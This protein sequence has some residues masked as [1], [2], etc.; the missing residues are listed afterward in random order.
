[1]ASVTWLCLAL[2]WSTQVAERPTQPDFSGDWVLVEPADHG[3]DVAVALTVRQPVIS[4]TARGTPMAPFYSHLNVDR[5]LATGDR[6]DSYMIGVRGGSV[7]ATAAG[8]TAESRQVVEW[9]GDTLV[10][11][12]SQWAGRAGDR[13]PDRQH[14]EVWQVNADSRLVIAVTDQEDRA[15]ARTATLKYRRR[16]GGINWPDDLAT[17]SNSRYLDFS[18]K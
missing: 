10:I 12:I 6:S 3:P 17:R 16:E 9:V 4:Q 5:H 11:T 15:E 8:T 2:L 7:Q 13:Q 18:V 1:M 14:T